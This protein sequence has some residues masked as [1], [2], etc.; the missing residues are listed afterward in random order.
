[1]SPKADVSLER[2]TQILDAA[3]EVFARKGIDE[4]R[5]DD[6]VQETGLSKGALYWYFKGKDEII[7]AVMDRLF[8]YE[9][10]Q[11]EVL[12][13]ES[14]SSTERLNLFADIFIKDLGRIMRLMPVAYEFLSLA[15]RNKSVQKVIRQFFNRYIELFIP[16]IQ[17]GIDNGEFR[18][19]NAQEMAL[20]L[21]AIFEGTLLLWMY[22]S[23][24]VDP[25]KHI[26][27]GYEL[28]MKGMLVDSK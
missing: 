18:P 24:L 4:A 26:R 25:D 20:A 11:F 7:G 21:G 6:I 3:E 27:S 19:G 13:D 16:V 8:Q 14:K 23:S 12:N 17:Q 9:F 1:M 5:M 10:S 2:Q 28:L 15:F 22:D